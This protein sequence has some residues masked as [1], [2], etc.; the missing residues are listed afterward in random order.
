MGDQKSVE[1]VRVRL[2]KDVESV[3][4]L[5]AAYAKS[6]SIDL[7]FQDFEAELESLPGKYSPPGGEILLARDPD[8]RAI[9]CVAVRPLVSPDSCEMKRLYV[10]PAGRGLGL[11]IKLANS[12]IDI[13]ASLGYTQIKLDTLPTMSEAINLYTQLGFVPTTPYYDTQVQ[14]TI[15]LVRKL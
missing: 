8:G 12:I 15:F 3:A 11:G 1:I 5:F 6:L 10:T 9:G 13:A 7:T 14:E 4:S 2:S